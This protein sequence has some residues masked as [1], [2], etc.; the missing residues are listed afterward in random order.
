MLEYPLVPVNNEEGTNEFVERCY[1][2]SLWLPD[3][4]QSA[5]EDTPK[6]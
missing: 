5:A 6:N 3:V 2:E 1:V 4:R